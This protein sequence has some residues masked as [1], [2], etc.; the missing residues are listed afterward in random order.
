MTYEAEIAKQSG[1]RFECRKDALRQ[2]QNGG[3]KVTFT[4]HPQEMPQALYSD[5]MGQ[6]YVAVIVPINEDET[7]RLTPAP[8][9]QVGT[10]SAPISSAQ[11][12]S[13]PKNYTAAAKL[14]AQNEKFWDFLHMTKNYSSA[15]PEHAE[16]YIETYCGVTSCKDI[17]DGT[18]AG[19]KF[20]KLYA[21]FMEWERVG[22]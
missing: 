19:R 18:E 10:A 17:K 2:T 12:G 5:S 3:V 16:K 15:C 7:P 14:L 21:E 13:K 6:R 11:A 20:A 8:S 9:P 1:Y 22:A 4:I